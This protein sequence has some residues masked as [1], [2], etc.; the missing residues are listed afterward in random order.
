MVIGVIYMIVSYI[1]GVHIVV[2]EDIALDASSNLNL[3]RHHHHHYHHQES[4]SLPTH[5]L[6]MA[7]CLLPSMLSIMLS[8]P[9]DSFVMPL[10]SNHHRH[11]FIQHHTSNPRDN[12][13]DNIIRTA[14]GLT[15]TSSPNE[16]GDLEDEDKYPLPLKPENYEDEFFT[17]A[18]FYK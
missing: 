11:Q 10:H 7:L 17:Y 18:G 9:V 13:H 1:H 8:H 4:S 12:Q 15:M 2:H 16:E 14:F 6:K 5:N 3:R